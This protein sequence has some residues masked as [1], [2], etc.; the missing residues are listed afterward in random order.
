[1]TSMKRISLLAFGLAAC[2]AVAV[3]AAPASKPALPTQE[4]IQKAFDAKDYAGVLEKLGRVLP[5]KGDAAAPYDRYELL[6]LKGESHLRLKQLKSA[7]DAFAAA[8]KETKEDDKAA[9]ARA[10]QRVLRE[11][12]GTEVRRHV[13]KRGEKLVSADLIDPDHRA[14]AFKIVY[15][16]LRTVA[17]PK[18]KAALRSESLQQIDDALKSIADLRDLEIASSGG[19]TENLA[20]QQELSERGKHLIEKELGRMQKDVAD[21]RDNANQIVREKIIEST[22]LTG[23]NPDSTSVMTVRRGIS[24]EDRV[25]LETIMADCKRAIETSKALAR[26]TGGTEEDADKLVEQAKDIGRV[27]ERVLRAK[28]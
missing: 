26:A 10:T 6:I 4:D 13:P 27:A 19:D 22:S 28:Y 12:K 18:V 11:A 9:I 2:V 25:H 3:S 23:R 24:K 17:Q 5:L 15:D 8:A 14:D 20:T 7:G 16:D 1:M 21:I